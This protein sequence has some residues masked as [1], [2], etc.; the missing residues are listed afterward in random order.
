MNRRRTLVA[1]GLIAFGLVLMM[2]R[3]GGSWN[4]RMDRRGFDS[5]EFDRQMADFEANMDRFGREL[6]QSAEA[7]VPE[8]PVAPHA[9]S[10]MRGRWHSDGMSFNPFSFLSLPLILF[11][12]VLL[13]LGRRRRQRRIYHF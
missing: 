10:H 1:W 9:P 11:A 5:S 8:A 6:E 12:L 13:M 3:I 7:A 2:S 4:N